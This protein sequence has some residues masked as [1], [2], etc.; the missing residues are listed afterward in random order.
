MNRTTVILLEDNR[1]RIR[2]FESAVTRLGPAYRLRTWRDAHR[3]VAECHEVLAD[4]A[5]ISLD[6]D[7]NKEHADSPDPGDGVAAA[8]F[9]GR[10]PPICPVILHTSNAERVWSM[11]NALRFGGWTTER[12][13]PVNTD[14]I[15]RSWLPTSRA[16]LGRAGA[17]ADSFYAPEMATDQRERLTRA[18]LS[19]HG[20]AMGDGIGEMMFGR[21]D[22]AYDLIMQDEL[23]PGPWWHTDDTEMAISLVEVLRLLGSVHQRTP[24]SET[25]RGIEHAFECRLLQS[26]QAAARLLGNGSRVTCP[27]TVPFTIWAAA[28]FLGRYRE[29]IAA[30]ASVGG[31]VDTNCAIV[32]GVVALSAGWVNLPDPWLRQMDPLPYTHAVPIGSLAG[33]PGIP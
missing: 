3:L 31:D 2:E 17:S 28:K 11:H 14:W 24:D 12:V 18:L 26:P 19:L 21:P 5:L 15:E 25:R 7:L 20:L 13:M 4:A 30:T 22:K 6:H 32:G 8:E 33:G 27:D 16:L 10:L 1:D 9:L 23:P 29:A